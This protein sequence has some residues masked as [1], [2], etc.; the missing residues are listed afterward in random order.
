MYA[1]VMGAEKTP[2]FEGVEWW[3]NQV[4]KPFGDLLLR[5]LFMVVVPIVFCSLYLGVSRL[6][7]VQKIG[8]LGSRTLAW[9]LGSTFVAGVI[10]I[11]LVRVIRPGGNVSPDTVARI[12]MQYGE[13]A[14]AKIA[15][16]ADVKG[17]L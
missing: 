7:S 12:K 3:A 6:G 16:S 1:P 11:V 14:Q 4:I 9:F 17:V 13:A 10:G 5:L 2:A 8:S 15:Q